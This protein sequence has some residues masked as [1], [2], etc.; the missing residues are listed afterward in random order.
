MARRAAVDE[1]TT[2]DLDSNRRVRYGLG[3]ADL[4]RLVADAQIAADGRRHP[5]DPHDERCIYAVWHGST[6][7]LLAVKSPMDVLVSQHADGEL[8]A[9]TCRFLN[10]GV[11]RGST[12]RGGMAAA[13]AIARSRA[14]RHVLITPDGPRGPRHRLQL[15]TVGLASMTRLPIVL[16]AIGNSAARRLKSWDRLSLPC[17][18]SVTCAVLSEP[19]EVPPG[20]SRPQLEQHRG[21]I[22]R[23]FL[24]LTELAERWATDRQKALAIGPDGDCRS[25]ERAANVRLIP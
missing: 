8:I 5:V 14:T 16:I 19:I 21:R 18:G 7:S 4:D 11:V 6:L 1:A 24:H 17:P 22:E 13:L 20:L 10:V 23:R 9:Q 2:S 12:T 15:G 3:R 25:G